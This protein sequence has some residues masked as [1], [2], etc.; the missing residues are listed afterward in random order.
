MKLYL[1]V[2][3]DKYELPLAVA[4]SLSELARMCGVTT[5]AVASAISH[6]S[7]G[8]YKSRYKRVIIEDDE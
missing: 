3:R 6:E 5:S 7:H 2:T 1:C 8:H 4:D